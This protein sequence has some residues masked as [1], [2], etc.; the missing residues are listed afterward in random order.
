MFY[1][2]FWLTSQNLVVLLVEGSL[3]NGSCHLN[4]DSTWEIQYEGQ[5]PES[6]VAVK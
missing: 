4:L 2:E 3:N 1:P 5:M 6:K